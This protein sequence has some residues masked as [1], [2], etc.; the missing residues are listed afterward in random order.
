M[1]IGLDLCDWSDDNLTYKAF[2]ALDR[3]SS[4]YHVKQI[5]FIQNFLHFLI[6]P[7]NFIITL[8]LDDL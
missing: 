4:V 2:L 5:V 1:A 6:S 8:H 7:V 3:S